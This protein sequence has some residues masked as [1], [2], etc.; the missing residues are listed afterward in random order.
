MKKPGGTIPNPNAGAPGAPAVIPNQGFNV[1]I[2]AEENLKL[3]V[4]YAR[5]Q[6]RVSQPVTP[7]SITSI[8]VRA[9]N[10]LK[11]AEEDH[12]NP[13]DKPVIKDNNWPRTIDDMEEYLRNHLGQMKIPL[14]YIVQKEET[15]APNAANPPANYSIAQDEQI[16]HA[17]HR[18]AAGNHTELFNNDN[19]RVWTLLVE[20]TR[21]H[22]CWTY[23]KGFASSRVGRGA[24]LKLREH[25]LGINN[26]NN[27]ATGARSE[28]AIRCGP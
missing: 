25:F 27:M 1:S 19:H 23:I 21:N 3:V 18:D 16:A 20:L 12:V 4:Y 26:I 17:P 10:D 11:I 5:H 22:L 15:V 6:F 7:A 24:F 14:A 9:L 2:R 8:G 13:T 28:A